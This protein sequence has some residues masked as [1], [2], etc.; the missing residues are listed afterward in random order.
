MTRLS[1][2]VI[3]THWQGVVWLVSQRSV[4]PRKARAER[5]AMSAVFSDWRSV[6]VDEE[7][8]MRR[9]KM[10]EWRRVEKG[11]IFEV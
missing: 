9:W 10:R 2:Q 3:P 6:R 8:R 11:D 7:R 5:K 1:L 4:R